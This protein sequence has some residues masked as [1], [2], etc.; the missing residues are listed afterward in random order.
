V[1]DKKFI[2]KSDSMQLRRK[3]QV[4]NPSMSLKVIR[5]NDEVAL[6]KNLKNQ[7]KEEYHRLKNAHINNSKHH[8]GYQKEDSI[9]R[10]M[11]FIKS[12]KHH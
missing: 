3:H 2:T 9:S 4:Q 12:Y 11:Q 1:I 8:Y 6:K 10:M 7:M 5:H